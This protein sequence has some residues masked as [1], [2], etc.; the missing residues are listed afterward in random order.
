MNLIHRKLCRS[1]SWVQSVRDTLLPWALDGVELGDD[2]LEIG[3]GFGATTRVLVETVPSLTAVEVDPA[4][5]QLLTREFPQVKVIEADG[6][7]LP[8][9]DNKFSAV[10]AFT[11]LHHVPSPAQQDKLFAEAFRVLRPGGTFAGLDSRPNLRF[12]VIHLFDTM[13]VVDPATMPARLAAVGFRDVRI[14]T[15]QTRFRFRAAKH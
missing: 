11:M 12:R 14:E 15:T 4:S 13:V 10:T 7:S 1:D 5:A 2:V 8:L 3:P 6:T 9:P